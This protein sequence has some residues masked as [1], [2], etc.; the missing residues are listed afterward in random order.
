MRLIPAEY[1]KPYLQTHKCDFV[2]AEAVQRPRMRFVPIKTEE[3]LD[4]R[5]LH[6][7][8]ERAAYRGGEPDSQS[9]SGTWTDSAQRPTL[10]GSNAA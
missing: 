4:L 5:A 10:C 2:D 7:V 6:R 9:S 8:R 3:Q 1:V